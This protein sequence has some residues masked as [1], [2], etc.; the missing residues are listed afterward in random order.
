M[1]EII[2]KNFRKE[3]DYQILSDGFDTLASTFSQIISLVIRL[4]LNESKAN[5]GNIFDSEKYIRS[6]HNDIVTPLISLKNFLEIQESKLLKSQLG[7]SRVQVQVGGYNE[8][9]E[10]QSIRTEP[11]LI[12]LRENIEKL[13]AMIGKLK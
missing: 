11:L 8:N 3:M 5:K 13:D 6:L 1:S 10:L 9:R 2:Q 7:L 4:E 12:E